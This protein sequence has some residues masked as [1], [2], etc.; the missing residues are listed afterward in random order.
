MG[1]T[2]LAFLLPMP[3]VLLLAGCGAMNSSVGAAAGGLFIS[4]EKTSINTTNT[5][6]LSARLSSGAPAAVKWSIT[7]G[8]N[9][10]ALGQGT[11]RSNGVYIPPA[12]LSHDQVQIEV[13][14]TLNS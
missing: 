12:L 5:D 7:A 11:I 8:Q 10:R 2:N 3:V 9:D 13:T 6:P 1:K 14:A 4:A